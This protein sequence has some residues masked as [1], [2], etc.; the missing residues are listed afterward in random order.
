MMRFAATFVLFTA[1]SGEYRQAARSI[2]AEFPLVLAREE[3]D[4]QRTLREVPE[5]VRSPR[6]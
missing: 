5:G 6:Y 1:H 3:I 4:G 2:E